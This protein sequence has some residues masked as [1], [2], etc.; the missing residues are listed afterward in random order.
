MDL[1]LEKKKAVLYK[2][3]VIEA[4]QGALEMKVAN[5]RP[6]S[7]YVSS[8]RRFLKGVEAKAA[9][10]SKDGKEAADAVE[11]KDPV[12]KLR[13][14]GLGEAVQNAVTAAVTAEAEG[15]CTIVK[16]QTAFPYME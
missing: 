1:V 5:A 4:P 9:E 3:T 12:D 10:D 13:I 6:A 11:A 8:A 16:I 2:S 15:L 7:F 14:S